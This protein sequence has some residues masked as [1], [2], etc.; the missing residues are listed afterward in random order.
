M[1]VHGSPTASTHRLSIYAHTGFLPGP[2]TL[3]LHQCD[4]PPCCNPEHL[5]WGTHVEN[6]A[7]RSERERVSNG[8]GHYK[9]ALT[10]K[11]VKECRQ[12]STWGHSARSIAERYG[13]SELT[14][15]RLL[16]G[17]TYKDVP[18]DWR[19]DGNFIP[20]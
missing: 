20:F 16:A 9:A 19:Y 3:A 13:V 2:D 5:V 7:E 15:Q 14:V 10:A 1:R 8:L 6:M 11:Q 12:R 17:E 4:N 18:Y